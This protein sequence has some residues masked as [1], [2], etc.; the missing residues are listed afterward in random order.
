MTTYTIGKFDAGGYYVVMQD[1]VVLC[2]TKSLRLARR[3]A[4]A[5]A[6]PTVNDTGEDFF[7]ADA[8]GNRVRCDVRSVVKLTE[9]DEWG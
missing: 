8:N 5:L 2:R 3:I 1:D 7:S 6:S 9:A 4:A